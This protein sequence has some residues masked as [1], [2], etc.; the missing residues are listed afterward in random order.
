MQFWG[1][2]G[3]PGGFWGI[4]GSIL[5]FFGVPRLVLGWI[6]GFFGV[7]RWIL[8]RFRAILGRFGCPPQPWRWISPR[9]FRGRGRAGRGAGTPPRGQVTRSSSQGGPKSPKFGASP[10]TPDPKKRQI[11]KKTGKKCAK[12]GIFELKTPKLG[13]SSQ[14]RDP[15]Q[16]QLSTG[17][18]PPQIP[19]IRD[20]S[21]N[22]RPRKMG[23]LQ[24]LGFFSSKNHQNWVFWGGFC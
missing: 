19:K 15:P 6:L 2:L 5:G 21:Q 24:N 10:K 17:G 8:G 11:P 14:I 1:F 23:N 7:P 3:F 22:S 13:L 4:F 9:G 18:T 12:I 20:S 16:G